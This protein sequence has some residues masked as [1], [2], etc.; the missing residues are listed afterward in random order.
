MRSID[1]APLIMEL[2]ELPMRYRVGES[3]AARML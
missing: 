2:L 1:L 3:R